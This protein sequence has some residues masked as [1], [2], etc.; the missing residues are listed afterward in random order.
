V[1]TRKTKVAWDPKLVRVEYLDE[2]GNPYYCLFA[3]CKRPAHQASKRG[4]RSKQHRAENRPQSIPFSTRRFA[5]VFLTGA[6][7][8]EIVIDGWIRIR[9]LAI[10]GDEVRLE[11]NFSAVDGMVF[12]APPTSPARGA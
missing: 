10:A 1:N 8:E 4:T 11:V 3:R 12:D 6:V 9:I 5:M 7:G 2:E